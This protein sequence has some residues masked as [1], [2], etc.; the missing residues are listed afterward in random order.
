[1]IEKG[2][3][4]HNQHDTRSR[5]TMTQPVCWMKPEE[6]WIM[7]NVDATILA[8]QNMG[9]WGEVIK[10][11]DGGTITSTLGKVEY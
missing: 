8:N 11:H 1:M 10:N 4:A 9:S 3:K 5:I 2:E 6:G 7:V